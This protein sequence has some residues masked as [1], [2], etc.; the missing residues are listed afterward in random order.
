MVKDG[1]NIN[2]WS[3]P[4]LKDLPDRKLIS[5]PVENLKDMMVHDIIDP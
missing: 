4:W 1:K 5:T 2:L 3:D